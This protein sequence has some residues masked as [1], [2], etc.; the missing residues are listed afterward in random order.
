MSIKIYNKKG[1]L[2]LKE[3]AMVRELEKATDLLIKEDPSFSLSPANDIS[4]L[5]DLFNNYAVQDVEFEETI[6]TKDTNMEETQEPIK[7]VKESSNEK[8]VDPFNR[9]EP[10]VRD[11]VMTEEF[12]E[13]ETSNSAKSSYDEPISFDD[14]FSI[15]DGDNLAS[16]S[17]EP[18]SNPQPEPAQRQDPVN[19]SFND[20]DSAKQRKK[21][22]RFA[23]QIV[24]FTCDLLEKGFEWYTMKDISE[25]KLAEYEI[26]DEMDLSVLL[27]VTPT[28]QMTVKEFFLSQHAVIREES[29]IDS[30]DRED[31]ADALTEVFLEKGIA[32]TPMQDLI[33]IGAKIV[34]IQG[35]KATAIANS[36]KSILMQLRQNRAEE[37]GYDDYPQQPTPPPRPQPREQPL[38]QQNYYTEPPIKESEVI[39]FP[40]K[41]ENYYEEVMFPIEKVKE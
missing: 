25:A 28:Q 15:P 11:Y 38:P 36:H 14:S 17:R 19:P 22:K 10:I 2:S 37:V 29:K 1:T 35:L 40:T 6:N 21:T 26:N 27:D 8:M 3:K 32:P 23:K 39:P 41:K 12:P 16:K 30:E 20:M 34:V 4:E 18:E 9:E 31:L 13:L 7:E 5:Q 24:S 33:I